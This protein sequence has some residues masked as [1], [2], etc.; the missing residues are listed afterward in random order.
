MVSTRAYRAVQRH[1]VCI[2]CMQPAACEVE[3]TRYSLEK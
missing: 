2:G 1:G 3:R